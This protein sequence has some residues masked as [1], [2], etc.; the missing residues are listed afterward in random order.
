MSNNLIPVGTG[1]SNIQHN[2]N[3]SLSTSVSTESSNHIKIQE[4]GNKNIPHCPI[5]GASI[6]DP[7]VKFVQALPCKHLYE[8]N[9]LQIH[10]YINSSECVVCH[11]PIDQTGENVSWI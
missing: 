7:S 9:A 2:S 11:K 8:Q 3:N 4:I 5:S 10:R 1:I 6:L